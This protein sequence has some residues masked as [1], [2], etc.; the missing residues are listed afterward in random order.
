MTVVLPLLHFGILKGYLL[1][2]SA[3]ADVL[4]AAE[5]LYQAAVQAPSAQEVRDAVDS[6]NEAVDRLAAQPRTAE[7]PAEPIDVARPVAPTQTEIVIPP[8]TQRMLERSNRREPDGALPA[9]A[10]AQDVAHKP[11]A[12]T[13]EKIPRG[14]LA[15][16]EDHVR[17]LVAEG[18]TDGDI[19]GRMGVSAP[20]ICL[21]RKKHGIASG[22]STRA[23]K[24]ERVDEESSD[25]DRPARRRWGYIGG[26]AHHTAPTGETTTYIDEEGRKVTR[27]QPG[28]AQGISP[29]ASAKA[30]QGA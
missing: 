22:K 28:Y 4:T 15:G 13:A 24:P 3:P 26:S 27:L 18:L 19:A 12:R 1:G 8:L 14:K 16:Q 10:G 23:A 7:K 21:F 9:Q 25:E 6:L 30:S 29:G 11:E 5:A 20:S 17:R 2:Q